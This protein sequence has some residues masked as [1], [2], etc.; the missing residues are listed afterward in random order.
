MSITFIV[1][2]FPIGRV[3]RHDS[4]IFTYDAYVY[5]VCKYVILTS[6]LSPLL[7]VILLA[8]QST[9]YEQCICIPCIFQFTITLTTC[10]S[11]YILYLHIQK[12]Y[13]FCLKKKNRYMYFVQKKAKKYTHGE[14]Y[15]F[16]TCESYS[17]SLEKINFHVNNKQTYGHV[18]YDVYRGDINRY[19]K[20]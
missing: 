2:L 4:S 18:F 11:P 8:L 19:R 14:R 17:Y 13:R 3:L 12:H 15:E 5:Q 6:C 1:K 9:I 16:A 20:P 7:R 10:V